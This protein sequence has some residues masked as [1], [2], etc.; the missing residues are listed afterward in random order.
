MKRKK[1][2]LPNQDWSKQTITKIIP[3]AFIMKSM[4]IWIKRCFNKNKECRKKE[5]T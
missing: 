2:H 5:K 4:K 1:D 3:K